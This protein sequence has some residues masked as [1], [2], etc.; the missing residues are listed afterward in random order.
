VAASHNNV[1]MITHLLDVLK[2]FNIETNRLDCIVQPKPNVTTLASLNA[3][4]VISKEPTTGYGVLGVATK[5]RMPLF[6]TRNCADATDIAGVNSGV[7]GTDLGVSVGTGAGQAFNPKDNDR[8]STGDLDVGVPALVA[9][10]GFEL[11]TTEFTAD[12]FALGDWLYSPLTTGDAGKVKPIVVAVPN[13]QT[14]IGKVSAVAQSTGHFSA[15]G[16]CFWSMFIPG[17]NS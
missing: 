8:A 11:M 4:V 17:D 7:P 5:H 2:G 15:A 3:G 14:Y 1:A 13:I 10:G 12:A 9:T 16:V 6:I